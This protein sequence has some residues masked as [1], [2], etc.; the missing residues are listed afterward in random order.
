MKHTPNHFLRVVASLIGLFFVFLI[1]RALLIPSSFGKFGFYRGDNLKE[2][3]SKPVVFAGKEVCSSC[4]PDA[5]KVHG[6]AKHQVVQC[7]NCHAPLP[8]HID[9]GEFKEAMPTNRSPLL[10]LRCHRL[11]P[12]RPEG[13][14]QIDVKKHTGMSEQDLPTGFCLQC[15][16]PHHPAPQAGKGE[17]NGK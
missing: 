9:N 3:M 12:S 15:H 10:C 4:H 17:K 1:V 7:E 2:Q 14:S 13:F 11:L 5:V 16:Q 6:E 8:L